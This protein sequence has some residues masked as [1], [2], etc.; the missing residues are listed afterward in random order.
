MKKRFI[1][2]NKTIFF[3]GESPTFKI[4]VIIQLSILTDK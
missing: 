3:E 4:K 1:E 2:T